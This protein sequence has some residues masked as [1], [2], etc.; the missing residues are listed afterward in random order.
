MKR[1][2]SITTLCNMINRHSNHKIQKIGRIYW[3]VM[4][5]RRRGV[6]RGVTVVLIAPLFLVPDTEQKIQFL[7]QGCTPVSSPVS[8][9]ESRKLSD[10]VPVRKSMFTQS[11]SIVVSIFRDSWAI[12]LFIA[13][14]MGFVVFFKML[15]EM[16][17]FFFFTNRE[18]GR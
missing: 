8:N 4:G 10:F 13:L 15:S 1:F 7:L 11:A 14:I 3:L 17:I 6:G 5:E 2:P 16:K 12:F 18:R 9:G